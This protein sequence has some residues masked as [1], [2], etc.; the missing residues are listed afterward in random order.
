MG[1]QVANNKPQQNRKAARQHYR[2]QRNLLTLEQQSIA[3]QA[4]LKMCM[5]SL[6]FSQFKTVACYLANDGELDPI[7]IIQYCWQQNIQV[8]LPVLDPCKAGHLV[9]VDYQANSP[10]Q[11]NIY[12]IAEPI[13]TTNNTISLQE[14]DLIFTPL[15]AFDRT[16][17][18]LGMGGGYYDRSL[19]PIKK[20]K[21]NTKI[22]GLAHN[23]QQAEKLPVDGW[24]IPLHGIVT[25]L[26]YF[27]ID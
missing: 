21:L 13:A 25:P 3:T 9:F 24:D 22:I 26:K 2:K 6:N 5:D 18:R 17:N 4:C 7:A 27:H 23:T 11:A 10:M 1:Q 16:G 19:A 15:V 20:E 8:L 14:I 12:G